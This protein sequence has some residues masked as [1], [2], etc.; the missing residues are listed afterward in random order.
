M[1]EPLFSSAADYDRMLQEGLRLSGEDKRYFAR[2]RVAEVRRHVDDV[3]GIRSVLDFGCGIGDAA[4][5]LAAA[6]PAAAVTG[7]DASR[8]AVDLAGRR[9]GSGRIR[10]V[11]AEAPTGAGTFDLIHVN[12]VLHHVTPLA[13]PPLVEGLLQALRPGGLL[14]LF[15]NNPWNPGTRLVM[16]R[17][18]FDRDAI[19]LSPVEARHLLRAAGLEVLG[20]RYLFFFPRFL[21]WFRPIEPALAR[22][23]LGGQYLV[24]ARR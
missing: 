19:P 22:V 11:A 3:A 9:H 17:I 2:G 6:F 4:A 5:L 10:F 16:R 15:E 13:R 20:T 18:P 12:G 8:E 1:S 14:F 7:I 21:A 23:P 24:L